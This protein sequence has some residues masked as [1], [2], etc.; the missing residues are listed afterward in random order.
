[1]DFL[2]SKFL[3]IFGFGLAAF[4]GILCLNLF[5]E[6]S[7]LES[8]N[9]LLNSELEACNEKQERLTKDY[10]TSSNNL[11]ACN[12]RIAL[13]NEAIKSA[14]VKTEVKESPAAAKIKKIYIENKSC[15]AELKAY[16]ELFE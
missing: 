14:Q 3:S 10:V 4:A 6:N 15:E 8:V 2:T 12:A 9:S 16:K 13:Q 1:M 5:L 7:K 11:N